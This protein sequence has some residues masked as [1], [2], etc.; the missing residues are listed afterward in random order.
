MV[1]KSLFFRSSNLKILIVVP[2]L[3]SYSLLKNLISSLN[4]QTFKSWRVVF[5]EGDSKTEHR[6]W[7][8]NFCQNN[9][10]FS[11]IYQTKKY[12]GI[13]GAMNQGISEAKSDEWLLF[14]G[15]DDWLIRNDSLNNLS[16]KMKTILKK[17]KNCQLAICKAIYYDLKSK[18]KGRISSFIEKGDETIVIDGYKFRRKLASGFSPPHQGVIFGPKSLLKV[19]K[20]DENFKLAA[21]LDCFL[22]L[23]RNRLLE[24][25]ILDIDLI[26]MGSEGV[27]SRNTIERLK[28]VIIAYFFEFKYL[29]WIPFIRRYIKKIISLFKSKI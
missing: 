22:K 18:K 13:F 2:T 7:I 8:N 14:L 15:S 6:K 28:E 16:L 21:D 5:I 17:N 29:F 26:Y 10:K 23:S 4:E 20:Y 25:A 11:I 3:N 9:K 1:N 12:K 27:S 24:I 19:N